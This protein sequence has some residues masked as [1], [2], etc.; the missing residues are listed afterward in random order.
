[1]LAD[2]GSS[3]G[4]CLK[5]RSCQHRCHNSSFFCACGCCWILVCFGVHFCNE[6]CKFSGF[7][8]TDRE[9]PRYVKFVDR[10]EKL[11]DFLENQG[12]GFRKIVLKTCLGI[13][14]FFVNVS[15]FVFDLF[16][17]ILR[18]ISGFKN[19]QKQCSQ[20]DPKGDPG[21]RAPG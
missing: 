11:S 21:G 5:S 6:F 16:G 17:F 12:H 8:T 3:L 15:G 14:C 13:C 2:F 7:A 4:S 18:V 10:I 9:R 19:D 1:M 20:I